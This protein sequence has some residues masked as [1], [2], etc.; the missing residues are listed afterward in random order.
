MWTGHRVKER[1]PVSQPCH[2]G[3]EVLAELGLITYQTEYDPQIGCN[4]PTDI[5]FTPAL[6]SALD[7]SE[8]A[9]VAAPQPCG[10]GKP[11]AQK[12]KLKPLEMDELIA[13]RGG[14]CVS[15]FAAIRLS[16]NLT[17]GS[18]YCT[19]GCITAAS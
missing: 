18:G 10:V 1:Q 11:A 16:V 8:V 19:A 2:A 15:V 5:T 3:A 7:V 14:S 9:V 17:A 13:K 4:I 12:Q 6:F